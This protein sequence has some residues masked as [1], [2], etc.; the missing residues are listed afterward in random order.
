MDSS[1][2]AR[3]AKPQTPNHNQ[4]GETPMQTQQRPAAS[5]TATNQLG[6]W[7]EKARPW[8]IA[9][10][11]AAI[12]NV[13]L[14][15]AGAPNWLSVPV[16]VTIGLSV[17]FPPIGKTI[18]EVLQ[19][20]MV[21]LH[22]LIL[23]HGRSLTVGFL[24]LYFFA[25]N[26]ESWWMAMPGSQ[27]AFIPKPGISAPVSLNNLWLAMGDWKF[28]VGCFIALAVNAIETLWLV[29]RNVNYL[30]AEQR[31]VSGND[32][33]VAPSSNSAASYYQK[34]IKNVGIKQIRKYWI[35][36]AIA[37]LADIYGSWQ[38]FPLFTP[39]FNGVHLVWG[40]L[41]LVAPE[42]CFAIAKSFYEESK[43]ER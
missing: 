15:K 7:L 24:A 20:I 32:S 39:S 34:A 1:T 3:G 26:C 23:G 16:A 13:I 37:F 42:G 28:Y 27:G 33:D 40:I 17:A 35:I 11:V 14:R 25:I 30:K 22:S 4:K 2:A 29:D 10:A 38:Q 36:A 41:V 31:K 6:T 43:Y 8:I 5:P 19:K 9:L 12:I 21:G 18:V